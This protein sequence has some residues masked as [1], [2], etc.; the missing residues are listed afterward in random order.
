MINFYEGLASNGAFQSGQY[1]VRC[2][3]AAS[4]TGRPRYRIAAGQV[5]DPATGLTWQR[6]T[7][8]EARS[9][10]A[11]TAYCADLRLGGHSWRLPSVKELA[12]TVD[13]SRGGPAIDTSAFPGTEPEGWYWSSSTAAAD[14]RAR[15]KLSY[16]DGYTSYRDVATGHVRCVR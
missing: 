11:A 9:A 10:R 1:N 3:R 5:T 7:A 12:T 8:P 14:P 13:E 16:D 2:V 6:A 4:G 15:W